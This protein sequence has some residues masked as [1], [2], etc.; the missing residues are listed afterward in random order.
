M[1]AGLSV[2]YVGKTQR[3]MAAVNCKHAC[4]SVRLRCPG[5]IEVS[6]ASERTKFVHTPSLDIIALSLVASLLL[7]LLLETRFATTI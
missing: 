6:L 1:K 3:F 2:R 5:A 4:A 7:G